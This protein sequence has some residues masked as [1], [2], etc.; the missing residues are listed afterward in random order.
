M[1][2]GVNFTAQ[3]SFTALIYYVS[4]L[5]KKQVLVQAIALLCLVL[6][7]FEQTQ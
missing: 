7:Y 5:W 3:G 6:T 1:Y 4:A 2:M